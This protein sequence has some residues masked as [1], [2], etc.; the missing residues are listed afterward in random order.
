MRQFRH[1]RWGDFFFIHI[2]KTGGSSIERALSIPTRHMT[3]SEHIER[4]GRHEW[5]RRFCFTVVRNPWSKVVSH[6]HYRRQRDLVGLH[7]QVIDFNDWIR[8]VYEDEDPEFFHGPKRMFAPQIDWITDEKGQIL[9][10]YIA[11]FERLVDNFATVA[12]RLG[13]STSLPHLKPSRHHH[14][15]THYDTR[16]VEIVRRHFA[17]DVAAFGYGYP[18]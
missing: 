15:S 4:Y 12:E 9:V 7:G 5:E 17:D 6:Y 11:R 13:R 3:A 18:Q 8:A 1:D 16:S 2:N 10:D 14:Y